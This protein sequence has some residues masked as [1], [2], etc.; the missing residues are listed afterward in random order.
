[1][2]K[3]LLVI[4]VSKVVDPKRIHNRKKW[5]AEEEER[6]KGLLT[7]KTV[8][9]LAT[10]FYTWLSLLRETQIR[11]SFHLYASEQND[12]LSGMKLC[13]RDEKVHLRFDGMYICFTHKKSNQS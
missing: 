2:C 10:L 13:F 11:L 4:L 5:R 1:M 8:Y 6:H 9:H 3:E 12:V 7:Q